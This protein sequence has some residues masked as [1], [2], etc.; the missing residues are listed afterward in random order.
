M[1]K[2]RLV[3]PDLKAQ[4]DRRVMSARPVQPDRLVLW[5]LLARQVLRVAQGLTAKMEQPGRPVLEGR[6]AQ[7]ALPGRLD[8]RGALGILPQYLLPRWAMAWWCQ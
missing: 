5:E 8:R 2:A 4:R 1:R 7:P 6:L 3:Q